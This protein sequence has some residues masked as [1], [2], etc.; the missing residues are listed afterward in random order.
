MLKNSI[1]AV[2]AGLCAT[3]ALMR[4]LQLPQQ[5]KLASEM[6]H[7]VDSHSIIGHRGCTGVVGIPE[8]T[9]PAFH[10]AMRNG[11]DGIECDLHL[12]K[13]KQAIIFHDYSTERMLT[14]P[15]TRINDITL[16]ELHSRKFHCNTDPDLTVP[17]LVETIEFCKQ[18]LLKIFLEIKELK[19]INETIGIIDQLFDVYS[20]YLYKYCVVISFNPVVLFKLRCRN[21][22]I[23][24]GYLTYNKSPVNSSYNQLKRMPFYNSLAC[25]HRI[26]LLHQYLQNDTDYPEDMPSNSIIIR[27]C[28]T[29]IYKPLFCV[30]YGIHCML[31]VVARTTWPWLLGTSFICPHVDEFSPVEKSKWK[32]RGIHCMVWGF[33]QA[34]IS[35]LKETYPH[36]MTDNFVTI[37]TDDA[38]NLFGSIYLERKEEHRIESHIETM[39][40]QNMLSYNSDGSIQMDQNLFLDHTIDNNNNVVKY[41]NSR[42]LSK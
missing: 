13:D 1:V 41:S 26:G 14:G 21:L 39:K 30:L 2:G 18:N 3:W 35:N 17:T 31:H 23:S 37:C 11:A 16:E 42:K 36:Y 22:R 4:H 10:Y 8:N 5:F 25:K 29:I 28:T 40:Q 32:K 24:I 6:A 7:N 19:Y 34:H 9:L 12:T 15:S 38:F 27:G 33:D 20:D